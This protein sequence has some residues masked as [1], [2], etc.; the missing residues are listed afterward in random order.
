MIEGFRA[1]LRTHSRDEFTR[2]QEG[3]GVFKVWQW[4]LTGQKG[5]TPRRS[6]TRKNV[7]QDCR[8][9]VMGGVG[10]IEECWSE[11]GCKEMGGWG[12]CLG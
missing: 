3:S 1:A 10:L 2:D 12:V 4:S 9:W 8:N 11:G 5:R 6:D 7:L